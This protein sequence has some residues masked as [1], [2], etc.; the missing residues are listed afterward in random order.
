MLRNLVWGTITLRNNAST[1]KKKVKETA[2]RISGGRLVTAFMFKSFKL[3]ALHAPL[4][5]ETLEHRGSR[6][7]GTTGTLAAALDTVARLLSLLLLSLRT[8]R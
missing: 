4:I 7:A 2:L 3:R 1:K 6:G 8:V 5:K